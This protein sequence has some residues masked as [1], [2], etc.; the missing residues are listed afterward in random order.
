MSE[1]RYDLIFRGDIVLGQDLGEVKARL[2]QL[3]KADAAR[4]DALFSGRPVPLKR[5][6]DEE[7]AKKYQ[8]VLAKA[9]AE[10]SMAPA[11]GEEKP[12]EKAS[13]RAGGLSLAPAGSLLLRPRERG[14]QP[15]VQVDISAL[16]LKPVGGNL[17]EAAERAAVPATP[18]TVPDFNLAEVGALLTT[19]DDRPALPEVDFA[20][21]HWDLS[22]P[23][24]DLLR[25]EERP[26][27]QA[28][29]VPPLAADLAP[30]GSDLGQLRE[31]KPPVTPDISALRLEE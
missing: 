28:P 18:V 6:L 5:N 24:E 26:R 1:Q 2:Q 27:V 12:R 14:E 21:N 17:L 25:P 29:P 9:G 3:F 15:G 23:G 22:A 8:Q 11:A 16:S 7:T 10:V 4:I 31:E 30:V 13:P 20:D 19:E